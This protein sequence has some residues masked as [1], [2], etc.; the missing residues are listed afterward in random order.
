MNSGAYDAAAIEKY[1]GGT[2]RNLD[3]PGVTLGRSRPTH[4]DQNFPEN[5][6]YQSPKMLFKSR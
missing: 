3:K 2:S 4:I 6:P 5:S 1:E